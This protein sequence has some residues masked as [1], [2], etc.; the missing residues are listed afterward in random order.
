MDRKFY[1]RSQILN[2]IK[3]FNVE[4]EKKKKKKEKF[5]SKIVCH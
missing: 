5:H 1:E 4:S 2:L 3:K